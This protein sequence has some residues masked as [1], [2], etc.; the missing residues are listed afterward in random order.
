MDA[1]VDVGY[2]AGQKVAYGNTKFGFEHSALDSAV[3]TARAAGLEVAALHVH[4]GWGMQMPALSALEWVFEQLAGFARRIRGLE[5]INVGGG[6]VPRRQSGDDPLT[7]EAWAAAIRTHLAPLGLTIACEPGTIVVDAAGL[8]VVEVNTVE[9]KAST[10]WVGIDAGHNV[11]VYMAHYGIPHEI[12]HVQ[13]P[14]EPPQGR[15]SVAGNINESNDVFARDLPLPS[16]EEGDLLALLPAGAYGT[17]MASDHCMRGWAR[18][19]IV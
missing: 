17:S 12:V 13:R 14:L 10:T 1:A 5:L 16:I 15:Y 3:D 18:E 11:N 4:C 6:L 2:G 7:P 8:L 9:A 19:V